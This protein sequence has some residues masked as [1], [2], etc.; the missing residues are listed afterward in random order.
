MDEAA[1]V[2]ESQTGVKVY[3]T[4]GGSGAVLSQMELAKTGDLYIP[5]SP[6]YLEKSNAKNITD[7][8][9][10]N[11]IAYLVPAICV[12]HGNPKNI[13]SL[14]DLAR[15]AI[16]VGIGNPSTVCVGLYAIEILAYNHLLPDVYKNI[17]TQAASCDNTATLISLK[18]VDAVMGW[19]VFHDWNPDNIDAIYLKPEQLPRLAYIPAAISTFS[20]EKEAA[21]A[22]IDFLTSKAGQDIFKKWGYDVTEAE[23]RQYAPKA[24]IGGEYQLPDSYKA[25]LK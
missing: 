24:S 20:K 18:S 12:Q 17:I 9:T 15:P 21:G 13:Q 2:F 16:T 14:A 6:D 22:F 25:L 19:S 10:A 5:G 3:L 11:I 1:K 7:P 8:G 23:A 4:Y